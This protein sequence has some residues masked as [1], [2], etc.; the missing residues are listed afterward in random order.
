MEQW[1]LSFIAGENVNWYRQFDGFYKTKVFYH[2]TQ[3][4]IFLVFSQMT[5]TSYSHKFLHMDVYSSF[6][7]NCQNMKHAWFPSAGEWISKL[8]YIQTIEYVSALIRKELSSPS[9]AWR[10]L[11]TLLLTG[12]SQSENATYCIMPMKWLT[13]WKIQNY[14]DLEKRSCS[15]GQG[16]GRDE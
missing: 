3:Q 1:E 10:K 15:G 9:R 13:F 14:G 12:R 6:I 5:E 8:W 4:L 2:T 11:K 16:A 7:Q